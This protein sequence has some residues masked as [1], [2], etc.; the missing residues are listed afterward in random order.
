M[1]GQVDSD[2]DRRGMQDL[3]RLFVPV[4][5]FLTAIAAGMALICAP[6]SLDE[7]TFGLP[8]YYYYHSC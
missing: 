1:H 8:F 4:N 2:N 7:S 5:C 6:E 3:T